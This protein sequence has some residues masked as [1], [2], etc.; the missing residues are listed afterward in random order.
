MFWDIGFFQYLP[1][2]FICDHRYCPYSFYLKIDF[3]SKISFKWSLIFRN[4]RTHIECDFI[5]DS[6]EKILF[7]NPFLP[8][9]EGGRSLQNNGHLGIGGKISQWVGNTFLD[10]V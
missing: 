8:N 6:R 9:N 5:T 2:L 7:I 4:E 3:S 10:R 1:F